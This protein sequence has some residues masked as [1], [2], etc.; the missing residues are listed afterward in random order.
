MFT[1]V[2]LV[3]ALLVVRPRL[4]ADRHAPGGVAIAGVLLAVAL[5]ASIYLVQHDWSS[6]KYSLVDRPSLWRVASE[7]HRQAPL[8]GY[9]PD[10][11]ETVYTETGE[12]MRSAQHS[13]HNQ[14]VDVVFNAGWVGA[15]LLVGM[16]VA[17]VWSVGFARPAV[18]IVLASVFLIGIGERAWLIGKADFVSFSL[19]G[20]IVLGP[21]SPQPREQKAGPRMGARAERSRAPDRPRVAIGS[22]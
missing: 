11:W 21:P 22:W 19:I 5:L 13:T 20:L 7:Y 2:V 3:V 15:A 6:A 10:K 18:L 1:V 9:G 17:M 12:I 14:W 16:M 8:F 4:D